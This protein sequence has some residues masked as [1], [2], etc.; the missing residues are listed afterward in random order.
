MTH[1]NFKVFVTALFIMVS[2]GDSAVPYRSAS[3]NSGG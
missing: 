2:G 3:A 1:R